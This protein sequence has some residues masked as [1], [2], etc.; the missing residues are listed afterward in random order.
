MT[1]TLNDLP[2]L[3]RERPPSEKDVEWIREYRKYHGT[4]KTSLHDAVKACTEAF[5]RPSP[6][7]P[8]SQTLIGK[9]MKTE[10]REHFE[11]F[12]EALGFSIKQDGSVYA[13]KETHLI[14]I[15]YREAWLK[16]N[17]TKGSG[18]D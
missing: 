4:E 5:Y 16:Q 7:S 13:D 17:A 15:G 3:L 6:G 8:S 9:S 11:K 2:R 18:N 10:C 14:W 12:A 1:D